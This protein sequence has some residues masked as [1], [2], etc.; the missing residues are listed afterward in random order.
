MRKFL[1]KFYSLQQSSKPN[2]NEE[3]IYLTA[4]SLSNT[5]KQNNYDFNYPKT[6]TS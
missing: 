6:D 1:G 4:L 2:S 3:E 5:H